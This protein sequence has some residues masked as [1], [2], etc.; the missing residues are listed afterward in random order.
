MES[1]RYE[2][3]GLRDAHVGY[4]GEGNMSVI[5]WP[6]P[7]AQVPLS[8]RRYA[9]RRGVA[10]DMAIRKALMCAAGGVAASPGT[11]RIQDQDHGLD[12]ADGGFR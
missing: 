4:D 9:G 5:K 2:G 11:V 10:R 8:A 1:T 7:S 3:M 12:G 6:V